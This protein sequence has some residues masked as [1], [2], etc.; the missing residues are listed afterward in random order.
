MLYTISPITPSSRTCRSIKL[1]PIT[2]PR[3]SIDEHFIVCNWYWSCSPK[4]HYA[5]NNNPW[6][7]GSKRD[8]IR[9]KTLFIKPTFNAF[10]SSNK[11]LYFWQWLTVLVCKYSL[12]IQGK[13]VVLS[14]NQCVILYQI[15]LG[16]WKPGPSC[17]MKLF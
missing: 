10:L 14:I 6:H 9:W 13:L 15:F 8:I 2:M 7:L 3:S 1:K 5:Y 17:K 12:V 4:M 16:A 11:Q